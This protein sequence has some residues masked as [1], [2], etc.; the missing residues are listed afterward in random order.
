MAKITYEAQVYIYSATTRL[1]IHKWLD[2]IHS[3]VDQ[4]I[5]NTGFSH[6]FHLSK[7]SSLQSRN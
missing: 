3:D 6:A 5:D 2:K 1:S 7:L 4:D